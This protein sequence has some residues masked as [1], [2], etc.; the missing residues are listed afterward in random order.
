[1]KVSKCSEAT[2]AK[3]EDK[4]VSWTGMLSEEGIYQLLSRNDEEWANCKWI[5]F[6]GNG[7]SCVVRLNSARDHAMLPDTSIFVNSR[8]I[9]TNETLCLEIRTPSATA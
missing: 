9:R 3:A 2:P 1:M 5:V 4:S 6:K 7:Q 8:F